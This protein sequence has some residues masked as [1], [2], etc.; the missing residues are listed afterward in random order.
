LAVPPPALPLLGLL[1]HMSDV[2]PYWFDEVFAGNEVDYPFD[3]RQVGADFD[4]P[5]AR[6]GAEVCEILWRSRARRRSRGA[7][8]W[9]L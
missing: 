4:N 2:A 9:T 8:S 5:G 3:P 6:P 1:R 7:R